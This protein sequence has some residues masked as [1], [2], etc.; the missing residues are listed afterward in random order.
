MT[1]IASGLPRSGSDLL[2]SLRK[3]GAAEAEGRQ[4]GGRSGTEQA[5]AAAGNPAAIVDLSRQAQE[6]LSRMGSDKEV[7]DKLQEILTAQKG[8]TASR[9]GEAGKALFTQAPGSGKTDGSFEPLKVLKDAAAGGFKGFDFEHLIEQHRIVDRGGIGGTGP[10]DSEQEQ[11]V[12]DFLYRLARDAAQLERE[13][14]TEEFQKLRDAVAN[15]TLRIEDPDEVEG[16]NL[17]YTAATSQNEFG[18]SEKWTLERQSTGAVKEALD[19]GLATV[20]AFGHLG[21]FFADWSG[22]GQKT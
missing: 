16:L 20:T 12:Q 10:T 19:K 22:G 21:A 6:A 8:G 14:K 15:G 1:Q 4:P 11:L 9:T 5:G 2:S 7:A 17:S 3:S 18:I 13:G